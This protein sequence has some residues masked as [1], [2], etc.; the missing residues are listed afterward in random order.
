MKKANARARGGLANHEIVTLAVYFLAGDTQRVDTEDIYETCSHN[1]SDFH[2]DFSALDFCS[3]IPIAGR[4]RQSV[5]GK[6]RRDINGEL[7]I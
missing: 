6:G 3:I 7:P 5:L 2:G 4:Y 1:H